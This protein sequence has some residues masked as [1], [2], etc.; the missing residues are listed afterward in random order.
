MESLAIQWLLVMMAESCVLEIM[1]LNSN[2][3]GIILKALLLSL[4]HFICYG[5]LLQKTHHYTNQASVCCIPMAIASTHNFIV[6]P[7]ESSKNK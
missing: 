7:T 1:P 2:H 4:N 6:F 5:C 3:W